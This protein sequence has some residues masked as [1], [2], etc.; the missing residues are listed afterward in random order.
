MYF[1]KNLEIFN[2]TLGAPFIFQHSQ[3]FIR[4]MRKY[5]SNITTGYS[6]RDELVTS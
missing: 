5:P 2:Q 6:G 3:L 1:N 4:N